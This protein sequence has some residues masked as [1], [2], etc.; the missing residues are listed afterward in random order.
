VSTNQ[1]SKTIDLKATMNWADQDYLLKDQ[2]KDAANLN[3][4]VNL[5]LRFSVNKVG[6][7]PWLFDHLELAS[8]CRMLELACGTGAIWL[9]NMK[10]IPPA[11]EITL[12]DF[13]PGMLAQARQNLEKAPRHFE[14]EQIE[15]HSIPYEDGFFDAVMANHMLYYVS[16]KPAAL[17]EVKRV[18]KAGG[19]FFTSTVGEHHMQELEQLVEQFTGR[20]TAHANDEVAS[21]VLENGLEILTPFFDDIQLYR[22]EDNLV[23]TEAAPLVD[24]L[25][26]GRYKTLLEECR[27]DLMQFIKQI[28]RIQGAVCITKDS[29]L[30]TA[31]KKAL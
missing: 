23:V 28:I 21:F 2:Y 25:L 12:S 14:F 31:T 6:W 5:H 7:F 24:Y 11:W 8:N 15:I 18:L 22:Y 19:R 17:T 10:R 9:D 26:S 30:F 29:G 1:V 20:K 16:D 13:S 27:D 4:R 3:A